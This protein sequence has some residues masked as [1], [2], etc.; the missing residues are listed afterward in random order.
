MTKMHEP[1]AEVKYKVIGY[2]IF[3]PIDMEHE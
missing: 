3:I 2:T 1:I